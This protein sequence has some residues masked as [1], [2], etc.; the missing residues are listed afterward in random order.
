MMSFLTQMEIFH[1]VATWNS[2]SKAAIQLG[3]SKGYVSTQI[4]SLEK[5]LGKKLLYRTTRNLS[6][7]E[8]GVTFLESCNKIV[9]EKQFSISQLKEFQSEPSG[10]LK[11]T[12]PPSMCNTFLAELIPAFQKKHQQISL[13]FDSS[14]GIKNLEQ[15]GIDIALRITTTPDENYIA[16][17]IMTFRFVVCATEDYLQ[18]HPSIKSPEDL[19]KHDCLIYNADPVANHW[20]FQIKGNT[21][22]ITVNN[23][24]SADSSSIIKASLLSSGGVAR[25]PDYIVSKEINNGS[26]RVLFPE[27]TIIEMPIYAI[28]ASGINITAKIHCFISFL[29][30]HLIN[31]AKI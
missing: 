15:H 28:Y 3:L 17:M 20:P 30:E 11:V 29:K 14:S 25:L 9:R 12:A 7:T 23:K 26:L 1:S 5:E 27:S 16:K 4:T 2:F 8:A 6:L 13:I 10:Q 22:I 18:N 21:K 19:I 31:N 24:L